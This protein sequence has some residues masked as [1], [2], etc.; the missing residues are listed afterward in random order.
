MAYEK[1]S[2]A[3]KVQLEGLRATHSFLEILSGSMSAEKQA[4]IRAIGRMST[5][6]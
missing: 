3:V 6:T 5:T 4:E 1:L 2:D